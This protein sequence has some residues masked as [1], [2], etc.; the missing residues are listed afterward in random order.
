MTT[1][2]FC[3]FLA[4][5]LIYVPRVVVLVAQARRP[6]GFDNR[7]PRDQQ[8]RLED[9]GRRANAAHAN[10]FEAF[11]PFAAAVL[12]AHLAGANPRWSTILSLVFVG[13]RTVYPLLYIANWDKLRTTV[14]SIGFLAVIGLFGL[15]WMG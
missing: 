13:A 3:V 2:F 11:A 7:H 4:F 5:L 14:W 12:I 15:R 8:A 10:S 9:W 1:P 6:E